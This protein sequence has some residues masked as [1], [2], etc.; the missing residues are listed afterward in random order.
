MVELVDTGD[1]KSP[2]LKELC[3]FN[4]RSREWRPEMLKLNIGKLEVDDQ[5]E[6]DLA[7][8]LKSFGKNKQ[9]SKDEGNMLVSA[10]ELLDIFSSMVYPIYSL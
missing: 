2:G 6:K 5:V 1:L 4:S 9:V 3:G 10:D 8:A 7:I